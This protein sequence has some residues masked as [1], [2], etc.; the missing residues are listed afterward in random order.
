MPT[1]KEASQFVFWAWVLVGVFSLVVFGISMTLLSLLTVIG[2]VF[3]TPFMLVTCWWLLKPRKE[4]T[5]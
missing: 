5:R 2:W 3:S 4:A 1:K